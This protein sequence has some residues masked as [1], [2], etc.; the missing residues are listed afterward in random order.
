MS[1]DWKRKPKVLVMG[2]SCCIHTGFARVLKE[3]C[4]SLYNTKRYELK[5][6]GWFHRQT[7]EM[8]PF[9]VIPTRM[10]NAEMAEADKY[11]KFTF[12][13]VVAEYK[14]DIVLAMGDTWM[15]EHTVHS[16]YRNTFKLVIYVPIDGQPIPPGWTE[17]FRGAD[18]VVSYGD[19][20]SKVIRQRATGINNLTQIAHGVDCDTFRPKDGEQVKEIRDAICA[21]KDINFLIGCVARNQPRKALP[22]LFKAFYWFKSSYT[23]CQ[24]CGEI[25]F[26]KHLDECPHCGSNNTFKGSAKDDVRLYLHMAIRDCGW[27]LKELIK[28]YELNDGSLAYPSNLQIGKGVSTENLVNIVNAFDIFTLPTSG[29]GWGLPI[30][31]AMSCGKPVL[32][33]D[34]S[35]HVDFVQGAGELIKVSEFICEPLTNIERAYVDIVDYV[36]QL[37]RLYMEDK[38]DF[39]KKWGAYIERLPKGKDYTKI[40]SQLRMELSVAA[41]ERAEKFAWDGINE[42]WNCLIEEALDFSPGKEAFEDIVKTYSMEEI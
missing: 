38:D 32:V 28:R 5:T 16:K 37:D 11:G 35:A 17:T 39:L 26:R 22:R 21:N 9:E 3:I 36:F 24:D 41:R 40:G 6:I 1:K 33:T 10:D 4:T 8:V 13:S 18:I 42:Q 7:E 19:F 30:L 25:T 12:D 23:S 15:V 14:P 2:D 34:Y 27:D 29:E 20:G 31:E